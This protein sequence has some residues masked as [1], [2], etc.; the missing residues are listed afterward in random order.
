MRIS[1]WSSDVCSSDLGRGA[2]NQLQCINDDVTADAAAVEAE[3]DE[4]QRHREHAGCRNAPHA[5]AVGEPAN[6]RHAEQHDDGGRADSA[7]SESDQPK[8][9]RMY[10]GK[11]LVTYRLIDSPAPMPSAA[12]NRPRQLRSNSRR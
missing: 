4:R 9:A 1:D 10:G 5:E 6:D 12:A 7:N 8:S 11:M 3:C 2:E